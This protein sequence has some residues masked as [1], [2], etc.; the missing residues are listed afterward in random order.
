MKCCIFVFKR[1]LIIGDSE[2]LYDHNT[3]LVLFLVYILFLFQQ[4]IQ[5]ENI[6]FGLFLF[7]FYNLLYIQQVFIK[8]KII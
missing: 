5:S 7:L 6:V 2:N 1:I 4:F 8:K 3:G